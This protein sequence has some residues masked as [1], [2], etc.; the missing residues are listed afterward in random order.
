MVG[1]E[2]KYDEIVV[3]CKYCKIY[4]WILVNVLWNLLFSDIFRFFIVENL[5]DWIVYCYIG[6]YNCNVFI[7]FDVY[8]WF[9]DFS[10]SYER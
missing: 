5:V 2:I 9:K 6:L 7:W 1:E 4:L 3:F 10:V 8:L